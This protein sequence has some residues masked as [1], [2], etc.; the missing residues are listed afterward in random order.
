MPKTVGVQNY[1]RPAGKR[2]SELAN[3]RRHMPGCAVIRGHPARLAPVCQHS[4]D[5][6]DP[7]KAYYSRVAID[8]RNRQRGPR[9]GASARWDRFD[10]WNAFF[11]DAVG[12]RPCSGLGRVSCMR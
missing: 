9:V 7:D 11:V 8:A 3:P 6:A 2:I 4:A 1:Q 10:Q 12:K 5:V